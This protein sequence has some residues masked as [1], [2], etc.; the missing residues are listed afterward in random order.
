MD[1]RDERVP[2]ST[3]TRLSEVH[4]DLARAL[5]HTTMRAFLVERFASVS[6]VTSSSFISRRHARRPSL[7]SSI[8][9][10]LFSCSLFL[11]PFSS[12]LRFF[13]RPT[14][15]PGLSR[16]P[17]NA[18]P[19]DDSVLL[20][21]PPPPS[22]MNA[23]GG[24]RGP[25]SVRLPSH[26]FAPAALLTGRAFFLGIIRSPAGGDTPL[27]VSIFEYRAIATAMT[28]LRITG[29]SRASTA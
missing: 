25:L 28:S 27:A 26:P 23:R 24:P 2:A 16:T 14:F 9:P 18:N 12:P 8:R 1:E 6:L 22:T 17:T 15:G 21:A 4:N 19:R 29:G 20:F 3:G 11:T 5:R 7:S 10:L 13:A